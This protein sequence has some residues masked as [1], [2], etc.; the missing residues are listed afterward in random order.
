MAI[1]TPQEFRRAQKRVKLSNAAHRRLTTKHSKKWEQTRDVRHLVLAMYHQWVK[2]EQDQRLVSNE[3]KRAIYNEAA[4]DV[5][6]KY[7]KGFYN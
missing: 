5:M 6:Y 7:K 1:Y 3:R 2:A 4:S